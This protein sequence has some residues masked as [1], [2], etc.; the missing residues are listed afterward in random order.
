MRVKVIIILLV[1]CVF[2]TVAFAQNTELQLAQQYINN[3]EPQKAAEVYAKLFNQDNEAF[4]RY[5]ADALLNLKNFAEAERITRRMMQNHPEDSQFAVMLTQIYQR[6]GNTAK[7]DELFKTLIKSLP[8]D[9]GAVASLAMQFYQAENADAAIKCFLQGRKLL[10]NNQLFSIELIS[11]YRYKRDKIALTDEYLNYVPENPGYLSQAEGTLAALYDGSADYE[12]LRVKLQKLL[13]KEP[14][15]VVYN[16][17]LIWQYLEQK[18]YQQALDQTIAVS[19]LMKEDAGRVFDLSRTLADNEAY[20]EAIKGYQYIIDLGAANNELYLPAK[21]DLINTKNLKVTAGKY[22]AADLL[23][24]EKDYQSLLNEFGTNAR[25]A[26]AMERLAKLQAFKLHKPTEARALLQKAITINGLRP[27]LLAA[28]KLDLG[29]AELMCGQPWEATLLYSQVSG[30]NKGMPLAQE[31]LFRNAR[32]AYYTGDFKWAKEQLDVLKAATSQLIANDAL[33]LSLLIT[34]NLLADT[35]GA[36]LKVYARA[37]L[38]IFEEQPEK[39]L[40]TLD[41]ITTAYPGNTLVD[42]ILMAKAR[43]SLQL[44]DYTAALQPLKQISEQHPSGLW[45]DDAVFMLGDLYEHQLNDKQLAKVYYQKIITAYPGSLWIG[46]A[47]KRFRILR[48]DQPDS[49]S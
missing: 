34:D 8:A 7:A 33:N 2:G 10:H 13:Q 5:Y 26:F 37:D 47:R 25:T 38:L 17:L 16:R 24:L 31:A 22:V 27:D 19:R 49:S 40:Q 3:S 6:Q 42:D 18:Q 28:C 39:A 20:D 43:I 14:Q 32:L 46:E 9:K 36:A 12:Q 48:G 15:Q 29:D 35:S 1:Y 11:L 21:I 44:K 45:A 30:S 23:G 41:S 4:Y